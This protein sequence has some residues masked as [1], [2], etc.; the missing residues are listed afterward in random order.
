[1][2]QIEKPVTQTLQAVKALLAWKGRASDPLPSFVE[3]NGDMR[4]TLSKKADCYYVTSL[5]AGCSCPGFVY[6]H[7]CKHLAAMAHDEKTESANIGKW[8]GHNGPVDPDEIK[9]HVMGAA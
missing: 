4:L 8:H 2:I 7:K 6:N 3:L 1:M 5:K 9:A